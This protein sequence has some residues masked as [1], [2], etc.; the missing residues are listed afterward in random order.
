MDAYGPFLTRQRVKGREDAV[1]RVIADGTERMPA[2]KYGLTGAQ[3]DLIVDYPDMDRGFAGGGSGVIDFVALVRG[4]D[5]GGAAESAAGG[6]RQRRPAGV[7]ADT[8]VSQ[9]TT[10]PADDETPAPGR[11]RHGGAGRR[12][13]GLADELVSRRSTACLVTPRGVSQGGEERRGVNRCRDCSD[14]RWIG[15]RF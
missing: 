14:T 13:P 1:R 11:P 15:G 7:G 8:R 2:F 9:V 10:R 6:G 5:D 4:R 12:R 3:I